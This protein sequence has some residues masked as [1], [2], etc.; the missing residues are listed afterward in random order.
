METITWQPVKVK[1]R[2]GGARVITGPEQALDF[3]DHDW[4]GAEAEFYHEA[5]RN[6]R[7][8]LQKAVNPPSFRRRFPRRCSSDCLRRPQP[9]DRYPWNSSLTIRILQYV[10]DGIRGG[11]WNARTGPGN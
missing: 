5:K 1:R 6:C 4:D 8:A 10:S 7:R 3:L 2:N 11:A 9:W